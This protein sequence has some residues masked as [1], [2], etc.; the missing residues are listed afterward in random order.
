MASACAFCFCGFGL[1]DIDRD[2]QVHVEH[3]RLDEIAERLACLFGLHVTLADQR[4]L[5]EDF[6]HDLL[7]QVVEHD[8]IAAD[9][10]PWLKT[11]P[12]MNLSDG[13]D[14][15]DIVGV[16]VAAGDIA[17]VARLRAFG[18]VDMRLGIEETADF[19]RLAKLRVELVEAEWQF[20]FDDR[21]QRADALQVALFDLHEFEAAFDRIAVARG[22]VGTV[23]LVLGRG[24]SG[25][26][27]N[28]IHGGSPRQ[29]F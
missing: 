25:L 10:P 19:G 4:L 29:K 22:W 5:R 6:P 24:R 15:R 14:I 16:E 12:G 1:I 3:D 9:I 23:G 21:F 18:T 28:H 26:F 20:P 11:D 8:G 13:T 17:P 2:C 27:G 7:D